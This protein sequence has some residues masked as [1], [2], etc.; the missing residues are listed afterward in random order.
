ME[1]GE[2]V[3][4]QSGIPSA[5]SLDH[6]DRRPRERIDTSYREVPPMATAALVSPGGP[7]HHSPHSSFSSSY[8]SGPP[9]SIP[10]MISPVDSRRASDD[11]EGPHRQSLPSISEVISGTKATSYPPPAPAPPPHSQGLPSPFAASGPRPFGDFSS[12]KNPSP[13]TLLPSSGYPRPDTL[14]AFSD[15][16]RPALSNRPAPP[17]LNTFPGRHPSPPVKM[18]QHEAE[19]RHA[20]QQPYSAGHQHQSSNPPNMYTPPARP[21]GQLPLPQYPVSPR[22]NG[23]AL[24]SPYEAPRPPMYADERD[25][26]HNR[27]GEYRST[28]DKA[29]ESWGYTE[30]LN[31]VAS[32]SRAITHFAESYAATAREQQGSQPIPSRLP[33]ENEVE[34]MISTGLHV[35]RKLEEVRDI[36]NH[37][38]MSMDRVRESAGARK[39]QEEDDIP[40]Y[41]E[42]LKSTYQNITEVKKRRGR[43]APPGRCHSCNRIDTPEW[44]R[45]PDGARTLCNAC[46]LHYAKLERRRQ[47]DQRSGGSRPTTG[48]ERN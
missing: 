24:P 6:L 32:S 16:S 44:R 21:P 25:Q 26:S 48:D 41:A 39:P 2:P 12:D 23:P 47:L 13:R 14:P 37:N 43:A 38:R 33:T 40:M 34:A 35:L 3:A 30:V 8:H 46:G 45:G 5:G 28:L 1:A 22:N 36:I 29:F 9:T 17:P 10:G 20:E 11:S 31:T 4:R 7:Y 15:P 42:P 27:D 18:E 19:Q